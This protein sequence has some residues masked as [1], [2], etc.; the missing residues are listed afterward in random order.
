MV[1]WTSINQR[2]SDCLLSGEG[3]EGETRIVTVRGKTF[4]S[5]RSVDEQITAILALFS[6]I[7]LETTFHGKAEEYLTTV[8]QPP[9]K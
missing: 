1:I 4:V 3:L 2:N 8:K 5:Q 7:L 9:I 6:L